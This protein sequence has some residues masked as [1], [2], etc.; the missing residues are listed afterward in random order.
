MPSRCIYFSVSE[1]L[2]IDLS[3]E[4]LSSREALRTKDA[5]RGIIST[6]LFN[7]HRDDTEDFG[8][9]ALEQAA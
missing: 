9:A 1:S 2:E 4:K 3:V 6:G 8:F 5:T 7:F